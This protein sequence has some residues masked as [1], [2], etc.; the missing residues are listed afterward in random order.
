VRTADGKV[1]RYKVISVKRYP[2]SAFP[3]GAVYGA[4]PDSELR[5]IT[6]GG[7]FDAARHSYRD[8]VVVSAV[9]A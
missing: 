3:S 7:V 8:N 4:T 1:L 6:C 5:L 9:P 2:K